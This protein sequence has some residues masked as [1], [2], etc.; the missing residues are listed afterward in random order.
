MAAVGGVIARALR[1][2]IR[3]L[4]RSETLLVTLKNRVVGLCQ[5]GV[6]E[7]VGEDTQEGLVGTLG[8]E[9]FERTAMNE[10]GGVLRAAFIVGAVHRPAG[11]GF[12]DLAPHAG[13]AAAA[14]IGIQ[15]IR[16]VQ[17]RLKLADIAIELVDAPR[18]GR[19]DGAF[20]ASCPF[21]EKPGGV[22]IILEYLGRTTCAVSYGSCPTMR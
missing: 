8:I 21:A 3:S 9:P 5:F 12:E 17:M 13:V 22:A 7:G 1:A 11:V 18:L 4:A 16:I 15:N 19:G 20:V 6:R 14:A 2:S 10:V